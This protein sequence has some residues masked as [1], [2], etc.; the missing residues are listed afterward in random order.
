[1][2]LDRDLAWKTI[3]AW[4]EQPGAAEQLLR[5]QQE[6]GLDV[7]LHLFLRYVTEVLCIE[8]DEPA[9]DAARAAVQTW[10]EQVIQPVREL[11]R[12]LK[13]M[14]GL[15]DIDASRHEW[16]EALKGM[17]VKAER[18]EFMSLFNWLERHLE[19]GISATP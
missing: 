12:T 3:V 4:Y 2:Q 19:R 14:P 18:V 11:R 5:A 1:M 10:R 9:Q 8:L 6:T 15:E 7:V 17:E 13:H 16:R